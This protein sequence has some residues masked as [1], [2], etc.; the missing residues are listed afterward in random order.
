VLA[1]VAQIAEDRQQEQYRRQLRNAR[2]GVRAAYR[3]AALS[4]EGE[5]GKQFDAFLAD[6]YDS[7]LRA[8]D[9]AAEGLTGKQAQRSSEA[10]LFGSMAQR[11]SKLITR[12]QIAAAD[13]PS[14]A[15][16]AA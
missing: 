10:T 12:I 4:V 11:A 14:V 5:F 16:A 15:P 9:E 1:V 6:F 3:D 7:E 13:E 2:D 8:V